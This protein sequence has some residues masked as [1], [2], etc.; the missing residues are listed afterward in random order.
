MK[1]CTIKRDRMTLKNGRIV[2]GYKVTAYGISWKTTSKREA[3][4]FCNQM[5]R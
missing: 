3:N 5:N 2:K 4:K 1:R